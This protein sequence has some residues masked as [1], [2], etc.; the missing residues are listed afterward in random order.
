MDLKQPEP[1]RPRRGTVLRSVLVAGV[2]I[3][4]VVAVWRLDLFAGTFDR[5]TVEGMVASMG[6]WGPVMVV[7]LMTIA[8]VASP[9][10]SAPI[11]L[12]SGAAYG[13]YA[14]SLYVAIGSEIGAMT[15]FLI[16]RWIGRGPIEKLLGDKADYGLLGSQNALTLAV[17]S[18]RLLPFVSFDAM[19]Y[20]AGLSKLHFWRFAIA[21]FAGILPASFVLAHVGSA[22]IKGSYEGTEWVVLGLGLATSL[23]LLLI[24]LRSKTR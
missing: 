5:A 2:V 1:Q 22:A 23:P 21:T 8:V 19:S 15:A 16:A 18:S 10:P 12:A 14:G 3:A 20:A 11:A 9:L 7:A 13:H 6:A 17:F 4:I 24:A